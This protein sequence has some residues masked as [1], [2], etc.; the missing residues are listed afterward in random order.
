MRNRILLFAAFVAVALAAYVVGHRSAPAAG[1]SG[2]ARK[3][4]YWVDPMHPSYR[5]DKPGTAPDCGM[6]LEPV[7]EGD[8]PNANLQLPPGA[9]AIDEGR[10]RL[11]GLRIETVARSE[12]TRHVRTTGRV[13]ADPDRVHVVVSGA[14]G[15]VLTLGNSTEG[16]VVRTGETLMTF[17]SR[18][19]RSAEQAY[20][21][22]VAGLESRRTVPTSVPDSLR[23]SSS[24]LQLAEEQLLA[25]GM[26]ESQVQEIAR[27]RRSTEEIRVDSPVDGVVLSRG[28]GASQRFDRG[29]ELFRIADLTKVWIVADLFGD[30]AEGLRP[31]RRV[32]VT[33]PELE[34][35]FQATVSRT[36]PWFDA[37]TRSLKLR[38]EADN[39][40]MALRPDMYVDVEFEA[41]AP[42]GLSVPA[43]AILDS[44]THRIVYVE[45]SPGVFEPRHVVTGEVFGDRVAVVRGL[46]PGDRV[47]TAGTFLVDSESRMRASVVTTGAARAAATPGPHDPVCGMAVDSVAQVAKGLT[48]D[49]DGRR[50]VFCSDGCRKRFLA[51]PAEYTADAAD[52]HERPGAR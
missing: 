49:H 3:V 40:G 14:S 2:G 45:S 50:W 35:V 52:T 6:P 51:D 7:Y 24:S 46:V 42:E 19:F 8:D 12:G 27:T 33:A 23:P 32:R 36:P 48:A 5:A 16:T 41:E 20:I 34:R 39:P 10:Q 22:A 26:G 28:L 17:Y 37:A 15:W 25:L 44:G 29:L 38:L 11:I 9:V 18:D 43:D 47:V 21:A 1:G 30:D 31:A 4:L 13:V